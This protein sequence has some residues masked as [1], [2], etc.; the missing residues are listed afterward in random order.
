MDKVKSKVWTYA[1]NI[2]ALAFITYVF[3]DFLIKLT[4]TL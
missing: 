1:F 4:D 3:Y 2:A